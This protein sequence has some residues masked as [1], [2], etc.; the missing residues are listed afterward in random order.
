[1]GWWT[2]LERVKAIMDKTRKQAQEFSENVLR[3]LLLEGLQWRQIHHFHS[4]RV[5]ALTIHN[6]NRNGWIYEDEGLP[7]P[8]DNLSWSNYNTS[9][10]YDTRQMFNKIEHQVLGNLAQYPNWSRYEPIGKA[11]TRSD[12]LWRR[13]H[14]AQRYFNRIIQ[15]K[16]ESVEKDYKG[17]EIV[18]FFISGE[19]F[20]FKKTL[21]RERKDNEIWVPLPACDPQTINILDIIP[22]QDIY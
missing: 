20:R 22:K 9:D 8:S 5:A 14:T 4:G 19:R 1:M 17:N 12:T 16:L 7:K 11:L 13:Y 18:E 6:D 2:R 10:L 15:M 3:P 21:R